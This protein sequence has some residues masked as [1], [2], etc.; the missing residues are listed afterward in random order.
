[1]AEKC[2]KRALPLRL[3]YQ[4]KTS[5][6][7]WFQNIEKEKLFELSGNSQQFWC[8]GLRPSHFVSVQET[9]I[10]TRQESDHKFKFLC[11]LKVSTLCLAFWPQGHRSILG[12]SQNFC[13][14]PLSLIHTCNSPFDMVFLSNLLVALDQV[15]NS[16][17]SLID[18]F[19][20][21]KLVKLNIARGLFK[22]ITIFDKQ[23]REQPLKRKLEMNNL[24]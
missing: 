3:P 13:T 14:D 17:D 22:N 6:Q 23:K 5:R 24:A 10:I 9:C 4:T 2:R 15:I 16:L 18:P 1:M 19:Y 20:R 12:C 8:H 11:F 21:E 7:F